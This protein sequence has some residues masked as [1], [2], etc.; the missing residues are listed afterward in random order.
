[1]E[2]SKGHAVLEARTVEECVIEQKWE[3]YTS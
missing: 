1:M 3:E 2:E